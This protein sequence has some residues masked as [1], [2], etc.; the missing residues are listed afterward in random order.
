ME[1]IFLASDFS[2]HPSGRNSQDGPYNGQL[3]CETY[4]IPSIENKKP[5]TIYL[6]G[7]RGYSSAFLDEAFGGLAK[8]YPHELVKKFIFI[9]SFDKNLIYR[10]NRYIEKAYVKA[11]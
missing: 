11:C 2:K 7:T 3:F 4:L 5:T 9:D 1:K 6:D 8:K 10:I